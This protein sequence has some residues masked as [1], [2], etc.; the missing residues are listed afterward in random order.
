MAYA[1]VQT[2]KRNG[3]LEE[4][5]TA[6]WAW[7]LKGTRRNQDCKCRQEWNVCGRELTFYI[8]QGPYFSNW[9]KRFL[10]VQ[11]WCGN[12]KP[13]R[14]PN[15]SSRINILGKNWGKESFKTNT[16]GKKSMTIQNT[17]KKL[18]NLKN[19][20]L[21]FEIPFSGSVLLFCHQDSPLPHSATICHLL[22][23][24]SVCLWS[25]SWYFLWWP[26]ADWLIEL[27]W[28]ILLLE[29]LKSLP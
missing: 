28:S 6:H 23:K 29:T 9:S 7:L 3:M 19:F 1:E 10:G 15:I 26:S 18:Y 20:S 17:C 25:C 24:S 5:Q 22:R 2:N 8:Q 11:Q 4:F 27:Q 14:K 16:N 21:C 13:K 12:S